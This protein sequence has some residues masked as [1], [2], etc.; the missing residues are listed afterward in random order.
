MADLFTLPELASYVQSDVDTATA[1]LARAGAQAAVRG[2]CRQEFTTATWTGVLLLVQYDPRIGY[3]VELPQR[4][5]TAVSAF[6][7]NG[8]SAAYTV[9]L[10]RNRVV[11]TGPFAVAPDGLEDQALVTYTSGYAEVPEDVKL[12]ALSAA[13]RIYSNPNATTRESVTVGAYSED[14]ELAPA[15]LN[16][17]ESAMLR[18]YRRTVGS[19]RLV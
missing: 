17:Y 6:T 5:V 1:T 10:M 16:E 7:V 9:D 2:Y 15:Q 12:V 4:P 19:V 18:R 14:R 8:S 3:Y 11:V 13:A